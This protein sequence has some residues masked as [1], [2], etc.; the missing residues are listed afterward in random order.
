MSGRLVKALGATTLFGFSAYLIVFSVVDWVRRN[1]N[2]P[3]V[4]EEQE[5]KSV[6]L[7]LVIS[8]VGNFARRKA[9]RATYGSQCKRAENCAILFVVGR[10]SG[11]NLNEAELAE[12]DLLVANVTEKYNNLAFKLRWAYRYLVE[13]YNA[14]FSRADFVVK[15]DDDVYLNL[16]R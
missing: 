4:L 15:V 11:I 8:H 6:L 16:A 5:S 1:S 10:D 7:L 14:N 13:I 12:G 3:F 2:C 9:I